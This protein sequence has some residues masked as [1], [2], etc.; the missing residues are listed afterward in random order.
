MKI[1]FGGDVHFGANVP[2]V[3]TAVKELVAAHRH[4]CVNLES[5]FAAS[6]T[7]DKKEVALSS[8]APASE[9][10]GTLGI[11]VAILANNHILDCDPAGLIETMSALEQNGVMLVGAG[12]GSEGFSSSVVLDDG[13]TRIGLIACCEERIGGI[14]ISPGAAGVLP[15]DMELLQQEVAVL[16]KSVDRV[17]LSVHWGL[18]NY[19]Y[20][21]PDQLTTAK[22][23]LDCGVDYVIGHHPH[24]AQGVQYLD[25]GVV[26]YSLGNLI[27][28]KYY[29][30]GRPVRISKEN[31]LGMLLS[32]EFGKSMDQDEISQFHT[33]Y[34]QERNQLSLLDAAGRKQRARVVDKLSV[35]LRHED[36]ESFY[37]RTVLKRLFKR[38]LFWLNP[39]SWRGIGKG[40]VNSLLDSLRSLLFK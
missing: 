18:T 17:L 25:Q 39:L 34:D 8:T 2:L 3:D 9:C 19:R 23:L 38:A 12:I 15:L 33:V 32:M 22:E 11:D 16:K 30:Q 14:P 5:P 37:K 20:P 1:L 7:T 31:K 13:S 6:Q 40:Q 35:P 36:Y 29:K 4:F 28:S 24:V 26:F 21:R 10:I 27:F